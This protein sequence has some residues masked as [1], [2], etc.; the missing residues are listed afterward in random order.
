MMRGPTVHASYDEKTYCASYDERTY[1]S[2]VMYG[3][4]R[5][6]KMSFAVFMGEGGV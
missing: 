3:K 5:E 4:Y 2:Q 1:C 6:M